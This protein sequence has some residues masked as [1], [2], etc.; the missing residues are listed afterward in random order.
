MKAHQAEFP[1]ATMCRVLEVST[2][3]YYK[4]LRRE[5]SARAREDAR[6]TEK[7]RQIHRASRGTYGAPRVHQELLAMG[8]QVGH[9]R[10]ARLMHE[11]QIEGVSRRR[12]TRTTQRSPEA[13]TVEDLVERDFSAAGPDQLW[14]SDITYIPTWAGFVYLAVVLDVWSRRIVGWSM[15]NHMRTSLVVAALEMA[16]EQ[17]NAEGVV[18]H[19]DHGSQYTAIAFGKRCREAGMRPSMGSV[20]DCY[21]NAMCESFFASLE[22]ELIDRNA[23][24]TKAEA[25]RAVFEYIE[26]FY[27]RTRR[28]S[29]LGYLSPV[30]FE[31]VAIQD[32]VKQG[33]QPLSVAQGT[34]PR[35]KAT[36]QGLAFGSALTAAHPAPAPGGSSP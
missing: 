6:L 30:E 26:S 5:P 34:R 25:K 31:R 17:R 4:W 14:V 20:G 24:R 15:A 8:E 13:E 10:V 36:P 35:V 11:A 28:H 16:I 2:S 18:F 22:C 9:N 23:W 7:I 29:S 1:I 33:L 21:D 27:N 19:S 12:S 3:G 32:D